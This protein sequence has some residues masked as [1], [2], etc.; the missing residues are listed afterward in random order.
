VL[1]E[2]HVNVICLLLSKAASVDART[3]NGTSAL[4]VA[5]Q[6]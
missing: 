6:V 5:A 4:H 1:Q 3:A 2:G